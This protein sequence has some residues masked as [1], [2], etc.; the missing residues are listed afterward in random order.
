VRGELLRA[1]TGPRSPERGQYLW[2]Q[3]VLREVGYATLA[4]AGPADP[5]PGRGALLRH[6][7]RR[8]VGR[9]RGHH[10][11]EAWR[12]SAEPDE[13]AALPQGTAADDVARVTAKVGTEIINELRVDE[14]IAF[15][16]EAVA[17]FGPD[18]DGPGRVALEGQLGRAYSLAQRGED[19]ERA[20]RRT[21]EGSRPRLWACWWA[22]YDRTL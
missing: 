16:E 7:R 2:V 1:E 10:Y 5:A 18:L 12:A 15:L 22:C 11:L 4:E 14:A 20:L 19:A 21:I 9:H 3:A 13:A 6:P 17:R 8:G